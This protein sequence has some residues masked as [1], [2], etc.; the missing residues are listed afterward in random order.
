MQP[1]HQ[2]IHCQNPG[3]VYRKLS[4]INCVSVV[5][6]TVRSTKLTTKPSDGRE[7][8]HDGVSGSVPNKLTTLRRL[9]ANNLRHSWDWANI[10]T[11]F[12]TSVIIRS[13]RADR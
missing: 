2:G 4:V 6:A 8:A 12:R 3:K 1:S 11:C 9:F 5:A 10:V 13:R 7:V